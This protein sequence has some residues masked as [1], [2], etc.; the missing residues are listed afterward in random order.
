MVIV[1][2]ETGGVY[3]MYELIKLRHAPVKATRLFPKA[4][5]PHGT[6]LK[7]HKLPYLGLLKLQIMA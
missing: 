3:G 6:G 7:S 1:A 5:K 4:V 2:H